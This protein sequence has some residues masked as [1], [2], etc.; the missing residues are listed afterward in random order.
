MSFLKLD[1]KW[2]SE[3]LFIG[4]RYLLPSYVLRTPNNIFISIYDKA[5]SF[6]IIG[7]IH[8]HHTDPRKHV[9]QTELLKYLL[10]EI[11]GTILKCVTYDYD[12]PEYEN[13]IE[14]VLKC[15]DW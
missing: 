12:E 14:N 2:A 11:P 9:A 5:P 4:N 8:L 3:A 1:R 15:F 13:V 6:K 7:V 10:T